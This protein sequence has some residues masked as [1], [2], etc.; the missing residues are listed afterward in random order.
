M[1]DF[2]IELFDLEADPDEL[3]NLGIGADNRAL[4]ERLNTLL[5]GMLEEEVGPVSPDFLPAGVL[6]G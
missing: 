2:E 6:P 3:L 4:V 1:E 5:N